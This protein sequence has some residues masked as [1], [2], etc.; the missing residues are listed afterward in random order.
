[1]SRRLGLNRGWALGRWAFI[2]MFCL[3]GH[4]FGAAPSAPAPSL[5]EKVEK[6]DDGTVKKYKVDE[7]GRKGGLY[8]EL[9]ASGKTHVRGTY[10]G[11]L[12]SG[13]WT[14]FDEKGKIV[15]VA[16]YAKGA[17]EGSYTWNGP[18]KSGVKA[19]Y[20]KGAIFGPVTVLDENGKPAR[21]LN[22]PRSL[23]EIRK[24]WGMLYPKEYKDPK[25]A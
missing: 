18:G 10:V 11:D 24:M 8:E 3:F 1:M 12:Q 20:Q 5:V 15:E 25:F 4:A 6:A 2:V 21:Q 14:T 16:V 19:T 17:R 22:Y 9:F 7:Q 23:E 13:P